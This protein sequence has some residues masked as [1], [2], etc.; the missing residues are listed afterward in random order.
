[1]TL[2]KE[3]KIYIDEKLQPYR[4]DRNEEHG[5]DGETG[6]VKFWKIVYGI[7]VGRYKITISR[8]TELALGKGFRRSIAFDPPEEFNGKKD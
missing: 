3:G 4:Y 5:Y 8:R 1:M 2:D 7:F 6:N